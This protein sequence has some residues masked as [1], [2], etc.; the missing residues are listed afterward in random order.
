MSMLYSSSISSFYEEYNDIINSSPGSPPVCV[1]SRSA[2]DVRNKSA[3]LLMLLIVSAFVE[4][5]SNISTV[6]MPSE[7]E[8]RTE[9]SLSSLGL[10]DPWPNSRPNLLTAIAAAEGVSLIWSKCP[11]SYDLPITTVRCR[12]VASLKERN[13]PCYACQ[14]SSW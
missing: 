11:G 14:L 12:L 1:P 3:M 6:G 10:V 8:S 4:Q 7:G 5:S 9:C 2:L 13:T